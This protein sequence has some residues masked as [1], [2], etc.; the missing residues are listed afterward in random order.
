MLRLL[1]AVSLLASLF[2][3]GCEDEEDPPADL[4]APVA[5]HDGTWN[6]DSALIQGTLVEEDGCLVLLAGD[7]RV[8]PAFADDRVTWDP[9]SHTL[10]VGGVEFRPGEPA[11]FGGSGTDGPELPATLRWV[12]APVDG[13][14]YDSIWLVQPPEG[15]YGVHPAGP[16]AIHGSGWNWN[17]AGTSG[18]LVDEGGCLLLARGDDRVLP[19]FADDRVVWE[20]SA[21]TLTIRGVPL[22]IGDEV[23]LGG[24]GEDSI[25]PY[26]S[27]VNPPAET[28]QYDSVWL[29]GALSSRPAV[30]RTP[31]PGG[32]AGSYAETFGVS[33][34][35]AKRRLELQVTD[36]ETRSRLQAAH[37]E[38]LAGVWLEHTGEFRLV[39]WYTGSDAGLEDARAIAAAAPLP[40]E[41]RSGA[42]HTV[43][44]L[45]AIQARMLPRV[46][47]L[48]STAGIGPGVF[49]NSIQIDVENRPPNAARAEELALQLSQEFGVHVVINVGR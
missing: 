8:L 3:A 23:T 49:T 17:Q 43:A 5:I 32:E 19:L 39:A 6:Y 33:I 21:R 9:P 18:V 48:F 38:R 26:L 41:I 36:G 37:A 45:L 13:C 7:Q 29:S 28:C 34:D 20:E 22:R 27:W 4:V 1:L 25:P 42:A 10:T 24:H 2:L 46:E 31:P 14:R 11:R 12:N 30:H 35:E 15:L 47:A 16:A 44:D 40:V